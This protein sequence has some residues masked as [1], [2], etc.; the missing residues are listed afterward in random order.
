MCLSLLDPPYPAGKAFFS[1]LSPIPSIFLPFQSKEQFVACARQMISDGQ[2]V[3]KFGNIL[4]KHC[5]DPRCSRELLH[6]AEHT[7]SISSQ[8]GI[9]A[10]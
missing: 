5:L 7:Q 2:V 9:V 6:A 3:V 10:R 1:L 4:A 8:L